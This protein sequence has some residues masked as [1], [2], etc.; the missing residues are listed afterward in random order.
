M[1]EYIRGFLGQTTDRRGKAANRSLGPSL[2]CP[3]GSL[4]PRSA[5]QARRP[6]SFQEQGWAPG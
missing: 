4:L 2:Q 5:C 1:A 3:A 6:R